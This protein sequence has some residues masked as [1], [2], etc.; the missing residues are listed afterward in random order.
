[1][2]CDAVVLALALSLPVGEAFAPA[3]VSNRWISAADRV[4]KKPLFASA[5]D[6]DVDNLPKAREGEEDFDQAL[7]ILVFGAGDPALEIAKNLDTYDEGFLAWL[8]TKADSSEDL[9]ER[10]ALRSL[11]EMIEQV[12]DKVEEL[13]AQQEAEQEEQEAQ[14]QDAEVVQEV[15]AEDTAETPGESKDVLDAMREVQLGSLDKEAEEEAARQRQLAEESRRKELEAQARNTYLTF[16]NELVALVDGEEGALAKAIEENYFRCDYQFLQLCNEE[17]A[18]A[19]DPALATKIKQVVNA[20]NAEAAK[21]LAAATEKLQ[22]I[23][24]AGNP[25]MMEAKV[26]TLAKQNQVDESLLMLLEANIQAAEQAGAKEPAE[27]LGRVL[28]RAND[29]L[30]KQKNPEQRLMARLLR[31]KSSEERQGLLKD[32]FTPVEKLVLSS[33]EDKQEEAMPEVTPPAFIEMV[34]TMIQNFGNIAVPGEEDLQRRLQVIA[35]E[36]EQTSVAIYGESL[37]ARE[38]QD[39]MWSDGTVSVF[40][41]ET[42]EQQ[43][44]VMGDKM[45]WHGDVDEQRFLD[46]MQGFDKK[47]VK[48][49]GGQ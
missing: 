36:A 11:G 49:I 14:M 8:T 6:F 5:E 27:V 37:T 9:E 38:Q 24:Q 22:S 13:A 41:L 4:Q 21:R 32:A 42:M 17:A 34:K 35:Q 2:R 15:A 46:A 19:E 40:D 28:R 12:R 7:G 30:N 3:R 39:R 44:E 10:A 45:P 1:M 16:V 26:A 48:K 20:V 25:T 23:L 47:G 18:K 33:T 31:T 29:E 43:A